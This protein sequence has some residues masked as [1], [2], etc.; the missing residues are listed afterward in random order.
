MMLM[1]VVA[2]NIRNDPE[3]FNDATL[4]RKVNEYCSWITRANRF[5]VISVLMV[6]GEVRLNS[7][8]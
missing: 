8:S 6:V 2:S 1:T 3:R 5:V 7:P 4:G